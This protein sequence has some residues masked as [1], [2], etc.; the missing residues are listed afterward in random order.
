MSILR[1]L[2]VALLACALMLSLQFVAH[3]TSLDPSFYAY[4]LYT[5]IFPVLGV[6]LCRLPT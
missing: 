1:L 4:P 6:V 5:Q 2:A 3:Q